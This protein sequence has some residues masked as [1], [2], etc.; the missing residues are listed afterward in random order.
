MVAKQLK[1]GKKLVVNWVERMVFAKYGART[2]YYTSTSHN[3]LTATIHQYIGECDL[4]ITF[5]KNYDSRADAMEAAMKIL[6]GDVDF[7]FEHEIRDG[8][9]S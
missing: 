4:S 9:Y 8:G 6:Y 1:L 3:G 7:E 2:D 5:H